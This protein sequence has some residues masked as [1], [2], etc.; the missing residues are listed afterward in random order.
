M[1][2][3]F[4]VSDNRKGT[5]REG[6]WLCNLHYHFSEVKLDTGTGLNRSLISKHQQMQT[7][8]SRA[9]GG[10]LLYMIMLK[11]WCAYWD[12]FPHSRDS[13]PWIL[14]LLLG[15]HN[16]AFT[17]TKDRG[18][19][20]RLLV[21]FVVEHILP[22]IMGFCNN[23]SWQKIVNVTS[24]ISSQRNYP[25]LQERERGWALSLRNR[26]GICSAEQR[27]KI[28]LQ[29]AIGRD[30][31]HHQRR[32]RKCNA[33]PQ[34]TRSDHTNY[35]SGWKLLLSNPFWSN[36]HLSVKLSATVLTN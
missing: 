29:L 11:L 18:R 24:K 35:C 30:H 36:S 25:F 19:L 12:E 21:D 32:N 33:S 15:P 8:I 4:F 28:S 22:Q 23:K 9:L 20:F 16:Q 10:Q 7:K 5:L 1:F 34:L 3:A 13:L 27:T 6:P 26:F 2:S 14:S 31:N 17:R